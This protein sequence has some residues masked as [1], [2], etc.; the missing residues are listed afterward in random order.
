MA[1]YLIRRGADIKGCNVFGETCLMKAVKFKKLC[2]LLID[3]GA[4]VNA[5]DENGDC[6]LHH[7]I[8][9][10]HPDTLHLLLDH[11]SDPYVKN[12]S[13]DDA[14]QMA[15]LIGEELELKELLF[16]M[17]PSLQRWIESYQLL[18]GYYIVFGNG[19]D[20][21][22][23]AIHFWRKAV[24]IQQ[25]NSCVE[26]ILIE[27]KPGLPICPGSEHGKRVGGTRSEPRIDSHV[28]TD[29]P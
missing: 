23:K 13:G 19:T 24:D 10:G 20:D 27:T 26:I 15:S 2:Q 7:T 5:Q 9:M 1:E 25:E 18:G 28:C 12:K 16:R 21:T 4:D 11:G 6:A 29:D 17:K 8:E 3:N 22:D 14:F